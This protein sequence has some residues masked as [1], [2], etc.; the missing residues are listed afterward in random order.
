MSDEMILY[1]MQ[2]ISAIIIFLHKKHAIIPGKV[3]TACISNFP[4]WKGALNIL[5]YYPIKSKND[6]IK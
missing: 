5:F 3:I 6:H 2:G 4:H 1:Q